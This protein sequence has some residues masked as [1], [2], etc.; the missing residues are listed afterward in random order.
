MNFRRVLADF[1][2]FRREYLRNKEGFF[3][4]L[5]FPVILI[6]LFGA[7]FSGSNHSSINVYA[8]NEDNGSLGSSFLNALNQ[9]GA[10]KVILATMT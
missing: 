3:F 1:S 2:V 7:I 6:L 8:L 5:V 9:T 4:A 10:I